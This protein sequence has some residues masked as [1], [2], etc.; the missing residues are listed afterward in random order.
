MLAAIDFDD[1]LQA[2]AQEI[3]DIR[4]TRDLMAKFRAWKTSRNARRRRFSASVALRRKSARSTLPE[5]GAIIAHRRITSHRC[6]MGR[7]PLREVHAV[8]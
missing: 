7:L 3:S 2:E 4:P 5:E 6:A 1:Q 8:A